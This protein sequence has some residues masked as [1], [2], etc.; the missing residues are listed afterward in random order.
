MVTIAIA[1][2]LHAA[3]AGSQESFLIQGASRSPWKQHPIESLR[4]LIQERAI[5]AD[6]LVCPG[7]FA[8]K[9]CLPGFHVG[10]DAVTE[11]A[12]YLGADIIG[13]VGNHDVDSRR[14][15]GGGDVFALAKAVEIGRASGRERE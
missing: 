6:Y 3:E 2:D 7:D 15:H 12:G 13:T 5:T 1:S 14:A 4:R 9:C 11:I 8:N 10:W